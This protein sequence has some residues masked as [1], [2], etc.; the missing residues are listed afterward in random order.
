VPPP[1]DTPNEPLKALLIDSWYDNYLGVIA[2]IRVFAGHIQAG[3]RIKSYHTGRKYEVG[4]VGVMYPERA[5]TDALRSGQVGYIVTGMKESSHAH[6]GDT[7]HLDNKP[8]E[9]LPGFSEAKPMVFAGIFPL[10]SSDFGKLDE[11]IA[12][13]ALNDRSI[14]VHKESSAALG[15]GWRIGFL[16]SLHL[17]VFE[18]RLKNEFQGE[19][20]ITN[21]TVPYKIT[22]PDGQVN[23]VSN[24]TD[25]PDHTKLHGKAYTYEEPVVEATMIFPSEYIGPVVTLCEES[26]GSMIETTYLSTERVLL[27]YTIPLPSLLDDFFGKLKGLT[28]GYASLDYEDSGYVASDLVK[29]N[30]LVNNVPV[31]ALCIVTHRSQVATLAKRWVT[32]LKPLLT[33]GLFDIVIQAS[34]NGKILARDTIKSAR[35]DVLAKCYGGDSSRKLK[36]LKKQKEG[37][38]RMKTFGNVQIESTAFYEF[39]KK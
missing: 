31:D 20:I 16:G 3:Q 37:K 6:I 28:R 10:D 7:F 2:L 39:L 25:F 35:K 13:L 32:K 11:D 12:H 38:K 30:M 29:L 24:P 23:L 27:K 26:R 34:C 36:L 5:K 21:P 18:D 8:V 22:A 1:Q 4:E 14:S 9:P 15:N 19:V 33:R 17:S